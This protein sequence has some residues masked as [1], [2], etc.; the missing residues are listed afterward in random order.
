MWKLNVNPPLV[1]CCDADGVENKVIS[2]EAKRGSAFHP[3][4]NTPSYTT[5]QITNILLHGTTWYGLTM[6]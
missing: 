5:V 4:L 1:V 6:G 3:N 2:D